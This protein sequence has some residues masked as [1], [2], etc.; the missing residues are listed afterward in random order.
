MGKATERELQMRIADLEEAMRMIGQLLI[1][2]TQP[3]K[4]RVSMV[5]GILWRYGV[6]P[7]SAAGGQGSR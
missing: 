7:Q 4:R 2:D 5:S 3:M 6:A 1:D